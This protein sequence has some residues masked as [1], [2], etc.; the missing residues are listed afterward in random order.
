MTT[1]P[2]LPRS[3]STEAASSTGATT[4]PGA[5]EDSFGGMTKDVL[6]VIARRPSFSVTLRDVLDG[7]AAMAPGVKRGGGTLSKQTTTGR[8]Q[9][10]FFVVHGHFLSYFKDASAARKEGAVPVGTLDL[11]HVESVTL[12]DDVITLTLSERAVEARREEMG[13]RA[14]RQVKKLVTHAAEPVSLRVMKR[15]EQLR[16]GAY[17]SRL[18]LKAETSQ[19]ALLCRASRPSLATLTPCAPRSRSREVGDAE[20]PPRRA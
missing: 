5:T 8:F 10:R 16:R 4:S 14:L 20:T 19:E 13:G 9:K 17:A 11:W 12:D 2:P 6:E 15:L 18:V 7:K 1:P 3:A